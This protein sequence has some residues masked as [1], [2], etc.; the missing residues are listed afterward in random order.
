[1]CDFFFKGRSYEEQ[2]GFQG[3]LIKSGGSA[4]QRLKRGTAW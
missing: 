2:L 4:A 3:G 1:M